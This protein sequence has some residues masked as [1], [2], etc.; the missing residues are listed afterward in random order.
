MADEHLRP[1]PAVRSTLS[2]RIEPGESPTGHGYQI[3]VELPGRYGHQSDK[4]YPLVVVLDGLWIAGTVR[5]AFRILP[6]GQ[7]LP[8]AIVATVT[9]TEPDIRQVVQE[10]AVDFTPTMFTSPAETGVRLPAEQLGKAARFREFLLGQV[11]PGVENQ[12]RTDGTRTL[13]GHS[14]SGLFGL[15]T[16]FAEPSAFHRWVL[17]SPSVW[18]DNQIIFQTES[19]YARTNDDLAGEV[20]LSIGEH[21][22]TGPYAGHK[23]FFQQLRSRQYPSLRLTWHEFP[24][25]S[26]QSVIAASVTRGLRTVFDRSEP[27]STG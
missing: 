3:D 12:T 21:E 27:A 23:L 16:L 20:F 11:I 26:H 22:S 2:Y 10:R 5:D 1:I 4:T 8:E 19:A 13:V 6:L 14:F 25:E 24:A 15:D 18:W 17:T 9:H 7:E